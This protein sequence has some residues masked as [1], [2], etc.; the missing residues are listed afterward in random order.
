[1]EWICDLWTS[2]FFE[3]TWRKH[4]PTVAFPKPYGQGADDLVSLETL[5]LSGLVRSRRDTAPATARLLAFE[6]GDPIVM[7]T[8]RLK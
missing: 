8:K 6:D 1:V 7:L 3:E 2:D 4:F 5:V